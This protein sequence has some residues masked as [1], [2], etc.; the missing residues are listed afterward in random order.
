MTNEADTCR[1]FIVPK[2]QSAGWDS[3][4]HSIAKHRSRRSNYINTD[5]V[6]LF[7]D[8]SEGR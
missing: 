2:L 8:V 5:L 6:L 1:K 3:D 4:P 7:F